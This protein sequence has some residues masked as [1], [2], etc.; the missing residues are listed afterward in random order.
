MATATKTKTV[1]A[2]HITN[3]ELAVLKALLR[4]TPGKGLNRKQLG[5]R[6]GTRG[7]WAKLLGAATRDGLGVHGS[8]SLAGRGL[9]KV[10]QQQEGSCILEY[11]ITAKGAAVINKSK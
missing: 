2:N 5:E 6:T 7:G 11:V 4:T 8:S 10:E 9:I 3:R 1:S